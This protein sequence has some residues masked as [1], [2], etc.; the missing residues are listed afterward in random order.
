VTLFGREPELELV[1]DRLRDRRLVTLIGPGGIG[2]TTLAHAAAGRCAALFGEG[3]HVV[4]LTR[5]DSTDGVRESLAAQ[6]GYRSF[7]ALIDAPG[8]HSALILV[9]NCEHVVDAV[10]HAIGELLDAC[11]MPTV[12]AT[13]RTAL[14]LPGEVIVPIGPLGLP[15]AGGAEGPAVELFVQRARDAGA[16]LA[17]SEAVAEL[18]RRLDGVPLA[19]ELAAAR[20][21]SMTPEEVLDRL[22]GGLDVLDRPRRRSAPRHQSLRAAIEWSFDLLEPADQDLFLRLTV[23]AGP[24]TAAS[25]HTVAGTPGTTAARTQDSLDALV[26]TSMV[27]ATAEDG[28]TRYRVLETLRAFGRRRLDERG[29][30]RSVEL[31]FVDHVVEQAV[32]IIASGARTWSSSA[33][34][35]LHDRYD[36]IAAAV[37]WCTEHDDEADRALLLVALLWGIIHQ[38]HTEDVGALAEQVLARWP[39]A[40]GPFRGDAIA[41]AATCRYMLG[42]NDGAISLAEAA[43][44]AARASAYAPATLRRAIAQARRATGDT[45]GALR[46]FAA[47]AEEA[48]SAGL[49]AMAVESDTARAQILADLGR[50]EEALQVVDEAHAAAAATGSDVGTTWATAIRGSV[51]LRVDPSAAADVLRDALESARRIRYHAAIAVSI[52]ALALADLCRGDLRSAARRVVELL[53]SL[54]E[55]GSTYELRL[56]LDVAS[57]LL[58]RSGRHQA[59]ADLAATALALPVVSITASVGHELFPVDPAG[60]ERLSVREAILLTRAEMDILLAGDVAPRADRMGERVGVFR[61]A[62]EYWEIGYE[63]EVATVRATK[64][65]RDLA[66]LLAAAG[67]EI[68][69]LDLAGGG[70]DERGTGPVLDEAARRSY[71]ARVRDLQQEVDEADAHHDTGRAERARAELDALVD[72]L[73]AALGLGGRARTSGDP[74]ERARSAVTQRIRSTIRRIEEVHPA[75]GRHLRASISTGTFC[76]YSPETPV[77]WQL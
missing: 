34:A 70:I 40:S 62:G 59:A 16:D 48:R 74:A 49:D 32:S 51:L 1:A 5:V 14:E 36:D 56:V 66:T 39:D 4:D 75:L 13:S 24:F 35:D 27:L 76:S 71:E 29:E 19:I 31:R 30:L 41:T 7:G 26:S 52:R 53:D 6:L 33:L 37:R 25:A 67:R 28:T 65:M 22:A 64:G 20:T 77:R 44:E 42:D 58:A 38:A 15:P 63:G 2:K 11:E 57:P 3:T 60:G 55:G 18:C 43:L 17:P 61:P 45:E 23:F 54:L 73:T 68:H 46:W 12:L 21:R 72:Q 9:D 69:S 8:D 50:I 47:T 10:A